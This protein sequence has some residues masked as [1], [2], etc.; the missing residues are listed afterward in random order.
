[1]REEDEMLRQMLEENKK[2]QDIA[3]VIVGGR[4]ALSN[5]APKN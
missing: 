3:V 2:L 4:A 1:M 5:F